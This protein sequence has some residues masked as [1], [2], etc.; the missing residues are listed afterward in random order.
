[1]HMRRN[2]AYNFLIFWYAS[3]YSEPG[4]TLAGLHE[5]GLNARAQRTN[6][7]GFGVAHGP[8]MFALL[9]IL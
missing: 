6:K 4:E 3:R 5:E 1:M 8:H 9:G 2:F 7:A